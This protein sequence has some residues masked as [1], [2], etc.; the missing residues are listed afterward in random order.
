MALDSE[1]LNPSDQV[2]LDCL[3]EGRC[4]AAYIAQETGYSKGNIRNRLVRL[5]EHGYVAQLGGGLYELIEDP[6]EA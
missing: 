3:N 6:R 5:V 2:I 1:Q 4:T